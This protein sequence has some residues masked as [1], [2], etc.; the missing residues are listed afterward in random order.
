MAYPSL[1]FEIR[2][3][4]DPLLLALN[5]T[6]DGKLNFGQKSEEQLAAGIIGLVISLF[7]SVLLL[8]KCRDVCCDLTLI[9]MDTE[10]LRNQ[11]RLNDFKKPQKQKGR[12]Y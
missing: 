3:S 4:G 12:R 1:T 5:L 7:I 9:F 2:H 10:S 11:K 6:P 8:L